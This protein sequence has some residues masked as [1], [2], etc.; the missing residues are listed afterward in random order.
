VPAQSIVVPPWRGALRSSLSG[1]SMMQAL[2]VKLF[3]EIAGPGARGMSRRGPSAIDEAPEGRRPLLRRLT[4]WAIQLE[5][6]DLVQLRTG[7]G[8]SS[9]W[10]LLPRIPGEEAADR[11]GLDSRARGGAGD[12]HRNRRRRA[13]GLAVKP[14]LH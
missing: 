7:Y 3:A 14:S 1:A 2:A 9:R 12:A 5:E 6:E 8:R 4:Y 11:A 10:T 13:L